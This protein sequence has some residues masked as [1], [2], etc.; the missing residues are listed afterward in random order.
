MFTKDLIHSGHH[1]I[2]RHSA[3]RRFS[4]AFVAISGLW[5]SSMVQAGPALNLDELINIGLNENSYVLASREQV[6][7]A[8][9]DATAARAYPNP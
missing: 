3:K 5:L 9:G 4:A 8:K 2:A 1:L 6:T 7:A